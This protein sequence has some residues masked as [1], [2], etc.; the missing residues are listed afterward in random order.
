MDQKL[1][2]II[3]LFEKNYKKSNTYISPQQDKDFKQLSSEEIDLIYENPSIFFQ[4]S[5][6]RIVLVHWI[7][8]YIREVFEKYNFSD[9]DISTESYEYVRTKFNTKAFNRVEFCNL[10]GCN[11]TDTLSY[12][13]F[14]EYEKKYIEELVPER[15]LHT[16]GI[17]SR[18]G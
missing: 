2:K 14:I 7:C 13:D 8:K 12:E 18:H 5:K 17:V 10:F 16:G 6:S 11:K 4:A 1:E 3:S 9:I 15:A